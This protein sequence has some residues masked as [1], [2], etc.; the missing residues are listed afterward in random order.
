MLMMRDSLVTLV[1]TVLLK[2]SDQPNHFPVTVAVVLTVFV[3]IIRFAVNYLIIVAGH[4][5]FFLARHTD[6]T[7]SFAEL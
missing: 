2:A 4:F 5:F 3:P 1:H 7:F 6:S